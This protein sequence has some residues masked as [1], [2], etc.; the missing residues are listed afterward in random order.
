MAALDGAPSGIAQ[1]GKGNLY[2]GVRA[3]QV[4]SLR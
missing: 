4:K 1:G 3:R 2:A